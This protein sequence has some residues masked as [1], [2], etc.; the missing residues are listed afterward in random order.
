[1]RWDLIFIRRSPRVGEPARRVGDHPAAAAV[2]ARGGRVRELARGSG[3]GAGAR[4]APGR[5][6]ASRRARRLDEVRELSASSFSVIKAFAVRPGFRVATLAR[7]GAASAFLLDG[8]REG[9]HG[10]TGRDS[11][12]GRWRGERIAMGA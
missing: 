9:L 5:R 10:G 8:F 12:I 6:A 2:G 7:Y 11:R 4:A 1:M 3:G